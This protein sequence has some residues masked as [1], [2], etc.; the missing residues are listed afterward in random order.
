M[1]ETVRNSGI[2]TVVD[3]AKIVYPLSN[4]LVFDDLGRPI[5]VIS[6]IFKLSVIEINKYTAFSHA[7]PF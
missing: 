3:Y 7:K 5:K 6:D 4:H 2:V 1:L